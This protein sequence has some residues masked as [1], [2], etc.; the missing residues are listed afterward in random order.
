MKFSLRS[1]FIIFTISCVL[2]GQVVFQVLFGMNVAEQKKFIEQTFETHSLSLASSV[3]AQFFERYGDI[4]A[5]SKNEVLQTGDEGKISDILNTYSGLYLIYDLIIMVNTE[6]KLIGAT[7]KD[8][9]GKPI[10][11]SKLRNHDFSKDEWFQKV[12]AGET[13]DSKEKGFVGTYVEQPHWDPYYEMVHG[14]KIL[15]NSFSTAVQDKNGKVIGVLTNRANFKWVTNEFVMK[16]KELSQ[17]GLDTALATLTLKDGTIVFNYTEHLH[18]GNSEHYIK[19]NFNFGDRILADWNQMEEKMASILKSEGKPQSFEGYDPRRPGEEQVMGYAAI[20]DPKFTESL[21]WKVFVQ[22]DSEQVFASINETQQQTLIFS[23]LLALI[24]CGIAWWSGTRVSNHIANVLKSISRSTEEV[25]LSSQQLSEASKIIS[26]GSV[27]T[28]ASIETTVASMEELSSMTKKNAESSQVSAD[29][30]LQSTQN[31]AQGEKQLEELIRSIRDI[32][33]SSKKIAEIINVIDDIAFQTNL[34]A[35]NAAVEAARAG[36]HGKGFAVVA[37]AVRTLAQRSAVAAKE[38]SGLIQE[39]VSK[40]DYGTGVAAESEKVLKQ[41][42]VAIKK[43]SEI[44]QEIAAASHEQTAGITQVSKSMSEIDA[45]SQQNAAV[46]EE[47][48]A[49]AGQLTQQS[50][51]LNHSMV[52]L[53]GIIFGSNNSQGNSRPSPEEVASR[54]SSG[55]SSWN[56]AA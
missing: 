14:Q 44:S 8:P 53:N 17:K 55:K 3:S 29:I 56:Q 19:E 52:D 38:I 23:G 4:Q 39:S 9:S 28:A 35:L 48:S 2:A 37:D 54:P 45:N 25:F 18:E 15:M 31:A 24:L 46:A 43:M 32:E 51:V 49:S 22:A 13:T 16:M 50:Q 47:L 34:L 41:L 7:T 20:N 40:I 12:M 5:F 10:D 21:G 11:I 26:S 30:S 33:T 42:I 1:Q 27:Q 36:D 6:G